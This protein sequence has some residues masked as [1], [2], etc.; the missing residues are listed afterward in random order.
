[1]VITLPGLYNQII[2]QQIQTMM[3]RKMKAVKYLFLVG[4]IV[5]F[6][7]GLY[8]W[9]WSAKIDYAAMYFA[10][11][12]IGYAVYLHISKEDRPA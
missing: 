5:I 6:L 11:S 8:N 7:L 2:R 4:A 3:E 10:L 12:A 9:L 1:M